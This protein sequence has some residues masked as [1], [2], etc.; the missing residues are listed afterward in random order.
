M[1]I[2]ETFCVRFQIL[3][4]SP[5][6]REF[7]NRKNNITILRNEFYLKTKITS[8]LKRMFTKK[9]ITSKENSVSMVFH[10]DFFKKSLEIYIFTLSYFRLYF[11][12]SQ[13]SSK[14]LLMEMNL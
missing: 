5:L 9:K 3:E 10:Q 13:N 4:Q 7:S 11:S 1:L 6:H 8:L 14:I 12:S 2:F